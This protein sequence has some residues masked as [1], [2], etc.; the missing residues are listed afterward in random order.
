MTI[1]KFFKKHWMKFLLGVIAASS[2]TYGVLSYITKSELKEINK[3]Y[4]AMHKDAKIIAKEHIQLQKDSIEDKKNYDDLAKKYDELC[5]E[6]IEDKKKYADLIKEY[7]GLPEKFKTKI[8]KNTDFSELE[9]ICFNNSDKKSD[10]S[11][12]QGTLTKLIGDS[13]GEIITCGNANGV[14]ISPDGFFLT[15]YH[16]Y[17]NIEEK[18][19][20]RE[21]YIFIPHFLSKKNVVIPVKIISYSEVS[22]LALYK[23]DDEILE[24]FKKANFN[25]INLSIAKEDL[26]LKTLPADDVWRDE[27]FDRNN[28]EHKMTSIKIKKI[29]RKFGYFASGDVFLTSYLTSKTNDVKKGM[30][31]SPVYSSSGNLVGIVSSGNDKRVILIPS[32]VIF[33]FLQ[34]CIYSQKNK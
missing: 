12:Q 6:A 19:K 25:Y 30:S 22:D 33:S 17:E 32:D 28:Y 16:V 2:L 10:F 7:L 34:D 4:E 18:T 31:G 14:F 9:A 5:K 15:N 29:Q 1:G 13:K 8:I 23:V 20:E 21:D 26:N 11:S 3:Y 27:D 24:K